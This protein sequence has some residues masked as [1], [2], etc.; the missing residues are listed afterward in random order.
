MPTNL[1][2]MT[3]QQLKER[4]AEID[5]MN[6]A[7]KA[8]NPSVIQERD[9]ISNRIANIDSESRGL[10]DWAKMTDSEAVTNEEERAKEAAAAEERKNAGLT[11]EEQGVVSKGNQGD[12]AERV[13]TGNIGGKGLSTSEVEQQQKELKAT[14]AGETNDGVT[15]YKGTPEEI[16]NPKDP[17]SAEATVE[18]IAEEASG[19]GVPDEKL[20]EAKKRYDTST[21][22]IWD[23]YNKG[24][25]SKEAAGY[26][27]VDAIAT[28]AKNLGR[29]VGNVGAQFTGGTIDNNKDQSMWDKRKESVFAEELQGEKEGL[30]SKEERTA[31]SEEMDNTLKSLKVDREQTINNLVDKFNSK[32]ND[33]NLTQTERSFY[34]ALAA[35]LAGGDLSDGIYAAASIS[36]SVDDIRKGVVGAIDNVEDFKKKHPTLASL[37][38]L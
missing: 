7:Q 21:M 6:P 10:P 19:N 31:K 38:G 4:A 15:T 30:G 32:A 16:L 34:A 33:K 8:S 26:F 28:F 9:E 12:N 29:G 22:G 37:L 36:G 13:G 27:T 11:K 23:A 18:T 1:D 35:D 3:Y 5:A 14:N 24:L 25:I 2:D 17:E 20:D